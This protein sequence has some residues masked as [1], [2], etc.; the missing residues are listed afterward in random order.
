MELVNYSVERYSPP[1]IGWSDK[2]FRQ[3]SCEIRTCES[4]LSKCMYMPFKDP[5]DILMDLEVYYEW[6]VN[7]TVNQRRMSKIFSY[8]LKVIRTL[9]NKL[10][11]N[12]V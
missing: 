10:R 1:G 7:Y 11:R 4:V 12:R 9:L 5:E 6:A 8:K 2:R 3:R